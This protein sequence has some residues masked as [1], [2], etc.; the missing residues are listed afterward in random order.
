MTN[1]KPK[2]CQL[3]E[4]TLSGKMNVTSVKKTD[5]FCLCF[6]HPQ[7]TLKVTS[8]RRH[9]WIE[10]SSLIVFA[11]H[12]QRKENFTG[13]LKAVQNRPHRRSPKAWAV[14]PKLLFSPLGSLLQI[15]LFQPHSLRRMSCFP[16]CCNYIEWTLM[17]YRKK[18]KCRKAS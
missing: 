13:C 16:A 7:P 18:R 5:M 3:Y 15:K 4:R 14:I 17:H 8:L 9:A 10:H 6:S 12:C 2:Y 11:S 1:E